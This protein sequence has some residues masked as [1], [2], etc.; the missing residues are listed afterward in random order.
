MREG[1]YKIVASL[2][3]PDPKPSGGIPPEEMENIKR[4]KLVDFELF[5]LKH[6]VAESKDVSAEHANVRDELQV[7]LT[8]MYDEVQAEC[9]LWPA[10]E[11]PRYE[12]KRIQWPDYWLNRKK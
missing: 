9:T 10:W 11:W 2:D 7:K 12:S 6:D 1:D 5:D 4:A 8:A 3:T